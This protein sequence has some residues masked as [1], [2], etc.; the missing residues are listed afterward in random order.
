MNL[1]ELP[2][3]GKGRAHKL[4]RLGIHTAEDL[5]LHAPR[6]YED[7]SRI[8]TL[9]EAARLG[10]GL[11]EAGVVLHDS[12]RRGREE[13]LKIIIRD[14]S[15]TAALVCFGR[16]V[17][18]R[19][20]PPGSNLRV[21]GQFSLRHGEI[22]SSL[23]EAE[24]LPAS[25][26]SPSPPLP[27]FVPQYPLTEGISQQMMRKAVAAAL[28]RVLPDMEEDLP[29]AVRTREHLTSRRE[30]LRALHKPATLEEAHQARQ[31]LVYGELFQFQL[32]LARAAL[33]RR[34]SRHRVRG[35]ATRTVVEPVRR[36]LPYSLTAD[37]ERVLEEIKADCSEP[38]PMA[39]LLQGDVGSGK[40]VVALL[41]AC[42]AVERGEQ[43]ALM[44]PTE[45]LA[46][47]HAAG[48]AR[49]LAPGGVRMA[50]LL[51]DLNTSQRR[52]LAG[53]LEEGRVDLVVGTHALFSEGYRYRNLGL[54]IIDEQHRFGVRQ[55][56]ELLAK[57]EIPDVLMM[58]AT[59][60]PRSLALT[61]FG[62][63]EISTITELPPGRR[64][65]TTRLARL[66]NEERVYTFVKEK[67]AQG[68]QAY[69]VYPAIEGGTSRELRNVT[70]MMEHLVPRL[71]P[72]SV[73][74]VHSRL[75]EEARS[76]TM[77]R[78]VAGRLDALVATSVIEVGVDV[79][80]ATVM[81]IEH[82]E[83]FGLAALHQLRGRVG[84]GPHQ[85][86][87]ILVFQE[88]LSEDARER[89]RVLYH[90]NDGFLIAEEDLRI[91]G[92]GDMAGAQESVR[93]AG[94]LSFRFADIRRDMQTMIAAREA[95][96]RE[97][98]LEQ[99]QERETCRGEELR[100]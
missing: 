91:R 69:L 58:S 55:R 80:N 20:F 66:G 59:P 95:V 45:L 9:V 85:S 1:T 74:F 25:P 10:E 30:A 48:A 84:R 37:Q 24:V 34:R 2:G 56:E 36:G 65:I 87:C 7:R 90:H 42:A 94:F 18:G 35:P 17:L 38:W 26:A 86:W 64:P 29:R 16:N 97:L 4:A 67:L 72:C 57:G 41:A 89:L 83:L 77:E 81:V 79:P 19:M 46:R 71:A 76:E 43:V 54:V 32:D 44:V 78:F 21:W 23:F 61:A 3:I 28:E 73:G 39:R 14:S 62:D 52:E 13:V 27:G 98:E 50:L 12:F 33:K 88:P 51:G 96:R 70:E 5:L 93:Q 8:V 31:R 75:S 47:Q 68:R 40:T 11:V 60:I 63:M 49:L 15:S 92:P 99:E 82:A 100:R 6:R 22:Q 53:A